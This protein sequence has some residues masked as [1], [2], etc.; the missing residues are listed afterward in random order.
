M[1]NRL[2]PIK[3]DRLVADYDFKA[4]VA[5]VK[6]AEIS[7]AILSKVTLIKLRSAGE[8]ESFVCG[9]VGRSYSRLNSENQLR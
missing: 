4:L 1:L 8:E 3:Y 2:D 5:N 7:H 6:V 9:I